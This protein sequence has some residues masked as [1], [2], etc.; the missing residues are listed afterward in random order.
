MNKADM[1][2]SNYLKIQ[3]M[4]SWYY[5]KKYFIIIF[6]LLNNNNCWDSQSRPDQPTHKNLDILPLHLTETLSN[7]QREGEKDKDKAPQHSHVTGKPQADVKEV[8][9]RMKKLKST[10]PLTQPRPINDPTQPTFSTSCQ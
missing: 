1:A 3:V 8:L 6:K 2:K 4:G 5:S 10:S 9:Q 7:N